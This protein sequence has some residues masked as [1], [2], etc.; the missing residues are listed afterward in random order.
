[1]GMCGNH[2]LMTP[3]FNFFAN[4]CKRFYQHNPFGFTP[5]E[6]FD[7]VAQFLEHHLK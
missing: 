6:K 5:K 4:L 1:M 7:N 2:E 3:H